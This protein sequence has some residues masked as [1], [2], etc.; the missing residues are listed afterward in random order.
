MK[1]STQKYIRSSLTKVALVVAEFTETKHCTTNSHN[2][3][4]ADLLVWF[5][6]TYIKIYIVPK[7]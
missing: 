3:N 6:H 5:K 4:A 2:L 1:Q 7:S